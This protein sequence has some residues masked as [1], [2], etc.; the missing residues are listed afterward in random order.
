[1]DA[2]LRLPIKVSSVASLVLAI[3]VFGRVGN[4]FFTRE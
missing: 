4:D 1:M 3:I 2:S